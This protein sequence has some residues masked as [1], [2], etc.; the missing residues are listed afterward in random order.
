MGRRHRSGGA[1]TQS[2]VSVMVTPLVTR[3]TSLEAP[4]TL[5]ISPP[6]VGDRHMFISVLICSSLFF[7]QSGSSKVKDVARWRPFSH[8]KT[9]N[10]PLPCLWPLQALQTPFCFK[11]LANLVS[12]HPC[13]PTRK[14]VGPLSSTD[15][16]R[17][18]GTWGGWSP[19]VQKP[20]SGEKEPSSQPAFKTT[21]G[22][23][24]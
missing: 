7:F 9:M 20:G 6:V 24:L 17:F 8:D 2:K 21:S 3:P 22:G 16:I 15:L 10:I 14:A 23:A 5:S 19:S 13:V 18:T 4:E 12:T 1:G 11:A